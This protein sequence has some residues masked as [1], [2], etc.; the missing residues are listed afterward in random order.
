MILKIA[1]KH[2]REHCPASEKA[3]YEYLLKQ[4][5]FYLCLLT[6][7][8]LSSFFSHP[9]ALLNNLPSQICQLQMPR[10]VTANPRNSLLQHPFQCLQFFFLQFQFDRVQ[11]H[12][13]QHYPF[14]CSCPFTWFAFYSSS[15]SHRVSLYLS[16]H[17]SSISSHCQHHMT[18]LTW[19]YTNI[20]LCWPQRCQLVDDWKC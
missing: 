10:Q 5:Q 6:I 1:R 7:F 16:R 20:D 8:S 15:L 9:I 12:Q 14:F 2:I 19:R 18:Y 3:C 13:R 4:A 11:Q 17:Q